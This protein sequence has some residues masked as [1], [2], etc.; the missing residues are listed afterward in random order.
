MRRKWSVP[1]FDLKIFRE[2]DNINA[3]KIVWEP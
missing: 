2:L 1:S 3:L